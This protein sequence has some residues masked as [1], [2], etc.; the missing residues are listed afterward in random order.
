MN[1]V[2]LFAVLACVV[3]A[4]TFAQ[5]YTVQ[6]VSGRVQQEANGVRVDVKAGD[7]LNADTIVHTGIGASLVLI[8]GGKTLTVPAAKS[9][10]VAEIGVAASGVRITGNVSQVNTTAVA[11]TTG[12]VSTASARASDAAQGEDIAAE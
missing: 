12:Q 9:G 3:A 8:D 4:F 1:K 2:F 11:R 7:K 6:S 5:S 10:T